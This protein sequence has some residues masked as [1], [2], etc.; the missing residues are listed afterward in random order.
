MENKKRI[1]GLDLMRAIAIL[2]VLSCHVLLIYPNSNGYFIQILQIFGYLGVELF[3]VLSGFLIG[4]ILYNLYLENDYTIKNVLMFL[5]RRWL[6][7]LPNFYLVLLLNI[8]ISFLIGYTI[9]DLWKYF[10]FFQNFITPMSSFF[11]ES[12][13][14]SVEEYAYLLLPFALLF[15][16]N[17]VKP[18]IKTNFFLWVILGLIFFFFCTKIFYAYTNTNTTLSQ[19]NLGIK[20]VVI[21]RIDAVF[22]GVLAAWVAIN[23]PIFWIKIRYISVLLG[24]LLFGF[25]FVGVGFFQFTI[26]KY[27]NFWNI[28]YLPITSI[29]CLLFL[30]FLSEWK[31]NQHPFSSNL[32]TLISKISYS[33]YLLHYSVLLQL[34]QFYFPS[35]EL[36]G[37]SLHLYSIS[38][39]CLTFAFSYLLYRFFEKPIIDWR[40]KNV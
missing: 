6:R 37:Y 12:W 14:L 28:F 27:P 39:L 7:T 34:L 25:L 24:C 3:F 23:L 16:T 5:K 20:A 22:F 21:Y 17:V 15:K 19:W 9:T 10:F 31:V 11:T 4:K 30:P 32:I 38:Y 36:V 8:F 1:F 29:M 13:S 33:I 2:M 40:D 26:E 18:N 35:K